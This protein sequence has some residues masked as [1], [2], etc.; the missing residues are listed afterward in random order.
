[1]RNTTGGKDQG[2]EKE[3][4][5]DIVVGLRGNILV[6]KNK[7]L[8][9]HSTEATEKGT[10][11]EMSRVP[12]LKRFSRSSGSIC[13]SELSFTKSVDIPDSIAHTRACLHT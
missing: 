4:E 5:Q 13:S 8:L 12:Q 7:L 2:G 10:C 11:N 1:M 9:L 6:I 3:D